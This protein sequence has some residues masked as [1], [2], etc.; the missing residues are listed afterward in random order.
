MQTN[1]PLTAVERAEIKQMGLTLTE[2]NRR[3]NLARQRASARQ[4]GILP[5]YDFY[6]ELVKQLKEAAKKL[7]TTPKAL[8]PL[9]DIHSI[10]GYKIFKLMLR[11]EHKLLHSN[12]AKKKAQ[13][14]LERGT[15]TCRHCNT[16]KSLTE[17]VKSTKTLCGRITTCKDCDKRLRAEKK[18]LEVA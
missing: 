5:T 18:A 9:V 14:I 11:Q 2:L 4:E 12:V 3:Y 1:K 15:L 8:F 13:A 10:D 17:F 6:R 7:N 16:D